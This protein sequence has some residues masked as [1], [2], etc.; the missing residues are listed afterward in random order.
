MAIETSNIS[1]T[2]ITGSL[3]GTAS[4]S[5]V[6]DMAL[7][8]GTAES[9]SYT[10]TASFAEYALGTVILSGT[11]VT[12]YSDIMQF[13]PQYLQMTKYTNPNLKWLGNSFAYCDN[14]TEL[15]LPINWSFSYVAAQCA[16]LTT[17]N[18]PNIITGSI[19]NICYN[20]S[21]INAP[22][23]GYS[24]GTVVNNAD[25]LTVL[26]LPK[27]TNHAGA[28]SSIIASNCDILVE[29][30]APML[31]VSSSNLLSQG[32]PALVSA[33]FDVLPALNTNAFQT[34]TSLRYLYV[35]RVKSVT[36]NIFSTTTTTPAASGS[37][38]IN[39]AVTASAQWNTAN[40]LQRLQSKG[41][42][43]NYVNG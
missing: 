22:K 24:T 12:E 41:W 17:I 1:A 32:N 6:A 11:E 28:G 43:I 21:S 2:A 16:A 29:L 37:I 34:S 5:D 36:A 39:S 38:W 35:P 15:N 27:L 30:K 9:A 8:A 18:L 4:F 42:T 19:C 14:L 7:N 20:V 40:N 33:S 31:A 25:M 13:T 10:T 26:N 3:Y 23:L